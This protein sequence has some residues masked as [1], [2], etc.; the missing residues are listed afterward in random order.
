VLCLDIVAMFRGVG[1]GAFGGS[2]SWQFYKQ[3]VGH[4]QHDLLTIQQKNCLSTAKN[5]V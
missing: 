5:P 1:G 4:A 2:Q 3:Q